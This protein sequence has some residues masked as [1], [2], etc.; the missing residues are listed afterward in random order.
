MTEVIAK[1]R[2][3]W[4][5]VL[6]YFVVTALLAVAAIGVFRTPDP[7][8]IAIAAIVCT[9]LTHTVYV[10]S[11]TFED[12]TRLGRAVAEGIQAARGDST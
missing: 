8:W 6:T 1:P 2:W 11:A 10:T 3:T 4:R 12:F 9:F 5:R 7:Q